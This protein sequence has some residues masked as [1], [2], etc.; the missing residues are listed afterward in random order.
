MAKAGDAADRDGDVLKDPLEE[1]S[2]AA[3]DGAASGG[4]T[5]APVAAADGEGDDDGPLEG[6]PTAGSEAE[7]IRFDRIDGE[8]KSIRA[9][10]TS[11]K[12]R[13][14]PRTFEDGALIFGMLYGVG[15]LGLLGIM[16][17]VPEATDIDRWLSDTPLDGGGQ[18]EDVYAGPYVS[19]SASAPGQLTI[20]GSN[21]DGDAATL[22]W[23]MYNGTSAS[24]N[25]LVTNGVTTGSEPNAAVAHP[26]VGHGEEEH[27]HE[28]TVI[29]ALSD[30]AGV[31]SNHTL[32][33]ELDESGH[34]HL[35]KDGGLD[36]AHA[37]DAPRQCWAV[38]DLSSWAVVLNL[39]EL[40]GG[41]ETAMLTGGQDGVPAW[42]MTFASL[43]LS[44]FTL[45]IIYP[46]IYHVYHQEQDDVLSPEQIE[47]LIQNTVTAAAAKAKI[48]VDFSLFRVHEREL[49]LDVMVA[50]DSTQSTV[51]SYA[52]IRAGLLK[53]LLSEFGVFRIYKPLQLTVRAIDDA[54]GVDFDLSAGASPETRMPEASA[55]QPHI[56][57]DY[58]DFFANVNTLG[59]IEDSVQ[60]SL[61]TFF[62][63]EDM[64]DTGTAVMSD[65]AA[66][67]IRVIYRPTVRLARIRFKTTQVDVEGQVHEHLMDELGDLIG[68][69][70]LIVSCRNEV[71]TL[72]DRSS[73]GR[74][75]HNVQ[76][77]QYSDQTL[78]LM[79]MMGAG[80]SFWFVSRDSDLLGVA[81]ALL[82]VVTLWVVGYRVLTGRRVADKDAIELAD[83]RVAAVARQDG[84]AGRV[85]QTKF[86]GGV[87]TTIEYTAGEKRDFIN[88][89]GF[90][91]LIFFVWIP[92]MASGVLVG[93]MLGL[94][95]RMDSRKVLLATTVGGAAASIT[96]AYTAEGIVTFMH[97]Y[98]LEF[99]IPIL[100][101]VF[102][103]IAVLHM[104]TT[105]K[106][107]QQ[108]LFEDTLLDT[109][110]SD[111]AAKYGKDVS[112]Q[113][114][115]S[116]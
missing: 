110:H 79:G 63:R 1:S 45:Y 35:G 2:D 90:W 77:T 80:A 76:K 30:D 46:L 89:W 27:A 34:I 23:W 97:E 32:H 49:S 93:S 14:F 60:E 28:L 65:D 4:G 74:L 53:A 109:F 56:I 38:R 16:W 51:S 102:I 19:F 12:K 9:R 58:S 67:Y 73:A 68:E 78:L 8:L 81:A 114:S 47:R 98:Q 101:G 99:F 87:I 3:P 86:F 85:L 29:A 54:Q 31:I 91:G 21:L 112:E 115:A 103:G 43:S 57:E 52:D 100:I 107:R 42:W 66:V 55:D 69:R 83:D 92:F 18:C 50:Y 33:L 25:A 111:I 82:S 62:S 96:W 88:K 26:V 40:G 59:R 113:A 41:R 95:S 11:S 48:D 75:E 105:K 70:E 61:A 22:S 37:H 10:R 104:R 84:V 7:R 20:S 72:A 108:E 6:M 116:A 64:I 71:H 106:R 17:L 36:Q 15:Y 39:A 24:A 13:K 5:D 44:L 94:V